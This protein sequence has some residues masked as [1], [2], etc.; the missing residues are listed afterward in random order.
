MPSYL[1]NFIFHMENEIVRTFIDHKFFIGN[2]DMPQELKERWNC[3]R[4]KIKIYIYNTQI[5]I[6]MCV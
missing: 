1:N 3:V 5:C 2:N 4:K 6:Y